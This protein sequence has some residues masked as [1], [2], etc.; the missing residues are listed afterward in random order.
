M[1][2][3]SKHGTIHVDRTLTNLS[4]KFGNGALIAD[5]VAPRQKV[6][7]DSD[8][9]FIY[10][11][12]DKRVYDALRARGNESN[13][14]NSFKTSTATYTLQ[15][16]ALHD[17]IG[18]DDVAD[19]DEA[20][21]L[22]KDATEYLT[23]DILVAREKRVADLLTAAAT[24]S[25]SGN[26]LALSSTNRWDDAA[27]STTGVPIEKQIDIGKNA[28]RNA[29]GIEPNYIVIPA[30]V[31]KY[32]K[33]DSAVRE[34]I[35]YTN[36]TL[37]VNGE[38]PPTMWNMKVLI[39]GSVYDSANHGAAYSGADVWGKHVL[40]FYKSPTVSKKMMTLA[41]TFDGMMRTVKEIDMPLIESTRIEV[42]EKVNEKVISDYAGY[43]L[44]TVIS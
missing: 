25:T 28:I 43:L 17:D 9:Y 23:N 34:L 14:I 29:I 36:N 4:I 10:G 37:L 11:K 26:V 27:F 2:T 41:L 21:D 7:R 15:K 5:E 1:A 33:R 32:V 24:F 35:K 13:G 3:D 6:I 19:A 8:S 18:Y 31:S 16:Y 30:A 20:L 22:K 38:L 44:R 12:E 42:Q 39:P 40:M